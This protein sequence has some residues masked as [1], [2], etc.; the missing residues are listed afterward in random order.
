[1]GDLAT[2][3]S[4]NHGLK[5]LG[6][7]VGNPEAIVLLERIHQTVGKIIGAFDLYLQW[8]NWYES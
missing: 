4:N 3:V 6:T 1:M 8:R 7:T 5:R 2:M